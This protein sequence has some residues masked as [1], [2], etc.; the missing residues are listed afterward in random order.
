MDK[1]KFLELVEKQAQGKTTPQEDQFIFSFYDRL[2]ARDQDVELNPSEFIGIQNRIKAN[3][4]SR[5]LK[6]STTRLNDFSHIGRI[7]AAVAILISFTLLI[8][9]AFQKT[10]TVQMLSRNTNEQQKAMVTL[11]DGTRVYLNSLSEIRFPKK[12]GADSRMVELDGEAFFEV[13]PD[14]DRPFTVI[15]NG[16]IT[17][18]L[19]TSFNLNA[20]SD[21]DVVVAV[22]T[23]KVEVSELENLS[24]TVV[25]VPNQ[26]ATF[27]LD[28]KKFLVEEADLD[29]YLDWRNK[30][31]SFDLKPLD[32]VMERIGRMYNVQVNLHGYNGEGCLIKATYVNDNLY[33]ILYGL[34]NLVEFEYQ[35]LDE[36]TLE[37]NYKG[38]KN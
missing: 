15:S 8:F 27:V 18:V 36:S 13:V 37:I 25:L 22:K 11:T 19:G 4:D 33:S 14:Q 16:V 20:S 10:E 5:I 21:K 31:I 17:K 29:F 9:Y 35:W 24:Q 1:E 7:A 23:G 12:F 26:K 38:C 28:S 32:K 6:K 2:Q 30:N 34:R 3:I